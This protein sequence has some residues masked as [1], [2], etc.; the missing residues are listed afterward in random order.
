[1]ASKFI[2]PPFAL[3][4]VE[5]NKSKRRPPSSRN[6]SNILGELK[7]LVHDRYETDMLGS[8]GQMNAVVL[9]VRD[10]GDPS[11]I[12]WKDP[13]ITHAFYGKK[14]SPDIIEVRYRIPE[15]H[16]HIPEPES[17]TDYARINLHPIAIMK[18]DKGMPTAGDIVRLDFTDKN[19]FTGAVVIETLNTNENPNA[20]GNCSPAETFNSAPPNLNLSQPAGDS[21]DSA[22]SEY[23]ATNNPAQNSFMEGIELLQSE[24]VRSSYDLYKNNIYIVSLAEY[25][26]MET[27]TN[28]SAIVE[29]MAG[30]NVF[31][32]CFTISEGKRLI[33]DT[34][35]LKTLINNLLN[36]GIPSSLL[37]HE[38][39]D[40]ITPALIH[41]AKILGE[42][43]CKG[44][45]WRIPEGIKKTGGNY[46]IRVS[47]IDQMFRNLAN[48][49]KIKYGAIFTEKDYHL[50][51]TP[52]QQDI[53]YL[54]DNHYNYLMKNRRAPYSD[55]SKWKSDYPNALPLY[56]LGGIN[57]LYSPA[58]PC[59]NGVRT[60]EILESEI[61]S[62]AS[63]YAFV[64]FE[65]LTSELVGLIA[66]KSP[67]IT[68]NDSEKQN[69]LNSMRK[70]VTPSKANVENLTG[71]LSPQEKISPTFNS[72]EPSSQTS[73]P[74]APAPF[75]NVPGSSCTTSAGGADGMGS[76][77][78]GPA[79]V[80]NPPS[81]R[82]DS[83]E[84]YTNLG[85]TANN[86]A[87][88]NDVIFDFMQ[89]FSAAVYRRLPRTHPAIAGSVHKKIRLTS[90]ARTTSKQ[91]ELMWD[92]I[93][94]GGGNQA[95]YGLYGEK[96]WTKK[97]VSAYH[98]NNRGAAIAAVEE[99]LAAGG[100][101]AHLSGKG[102]DVH[103][104]SH[105]DA[106]GIKS[107]KATIATMKTSKY[108]QAII[109]ACAETNA[110][111]TV[112]AYQQHVHITIR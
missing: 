13:L 100:G 40:E 106:E 18:K 39:I 35:R 17:P 25:I 27:F 94:N 52:V 87:I 109:A 47:K 16:A 61:E 66:E 68:P 83:I 101:S 76:P 28:T 77:M 2:P 41:A 24:E 38:S 69:L 80:V 56:F 29:A 84:N 72:D 64:N 53:T 73:S 60:E 30:K 90:T 14:S 97:V 50:H 85:W 104:W 107:S 15:I 102:V 23:S 81:F 21:Q 89:R 111:P 59:V 70:I 105:L 55:T 31:S 12:A 42:V 96:T 11:I 4:N 62:G 108:I 49:R 99:R 32:V 58:K 91:V 57:L 44:I 5:T 86:S 7:G 9:E 74:I 43:S 78:T 75:S 45:Y 46:D 26:K 33:R 10:P 63:G 34:K 22:K 93:K 95:V 92:K 19:N 54:A 112:E 37:I 36:S 51:T 98:A 110:K 8:V 82:F 71:F 88:I 48:S 3:N 20:G 1:M 65:Y 67:S 103:T 6:K 79:S